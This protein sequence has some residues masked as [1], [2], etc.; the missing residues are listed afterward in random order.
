MQTDQIELFIYVNKYKRIRKT[1]WLYDITSE[2]KTYNA[3]ET[4][5]L[6]YLIFLISSKYSLKKSQPRDPCFFLF[7]F[8]FET[9]FCSCYPVW[10]AMGRSRLT[11]TSASWVQAIL[12]PQPPEQLGLQARTTMP[13]KFF[14]F[15]SREGVSPC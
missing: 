15:F 1:S 3:L 14:V 7:L 13:S 2:H 9:E 4:R 6:I 12:L 10:S 5:D 11:T 8:F